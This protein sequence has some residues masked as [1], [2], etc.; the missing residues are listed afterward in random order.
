M[1][2]SPSPLPEA[3]RAKI[4]AALQQRL[5]DGLDLWSQVKVAHWN[6]KGPHFASLHALFETLATTLALHNDEVAE[7]A[8]TLG[9]V[10]KGAAASVAQGSTLPK[11]PEGATKDLELVQLLSD[12]L[13]KYLEGARDARRV[14]DAEGD[15][16]TV[17]LL[18]EIVTEHEKNAWFLR[19]TLGG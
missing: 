3:S 8:V 17:G 2:R 12:R 4:A 15:E 14:A 5:V 9:A 13:E 7:R 19:A 18:S 1:Y 16:D 6:V 10:V 11:W